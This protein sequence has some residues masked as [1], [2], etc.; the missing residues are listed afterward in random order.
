VTL[1]REIFCQKNV[2]GTAPANR[3]VSCGYF[4]VSGQGNRVLTPGSSVVVEKIVRSAAADSESRSILHRR[5]VPVS[6]FS[7]HERLERGQKIFDVRLPV[8]SSVDPNIAWHGF[9]SGGQHSA[10]NGQPR[11]KAWAPVLMVH[12]SR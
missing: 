4:D 1:P 12:D 8:V 11:L 6:P 5:A 2:S 7:V 9:F 3:A 10:I